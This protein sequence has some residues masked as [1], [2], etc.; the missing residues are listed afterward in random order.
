MDKVNFK[1]Y[2]NSRYRST[3]YFYDWARVTKEGKIQRAK[4]ETFSEM[5]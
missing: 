5:A 1:D 4:I 3:P 2:R